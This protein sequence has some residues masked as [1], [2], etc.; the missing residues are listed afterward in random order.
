M[1][2]IISILAIDEEWG[3]GKNWDIPWQS[4]LKN[5]KE[6]TTHTF[7]PDK[8]NVLIMGKNTWESIPENFRPFAHRVNYIV[9]SSIDTSTLSSDI[10]VFLSL[11]AAIQKALCDTKIE[12]IF[13][14]GWAGIYNQAFAENLNDEIYITK[15]SGTYECDTFVKIDFE[16]YEIYQESDIPVG[17]HMYKLLKYKKI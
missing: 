9:S 12:T 2:K 1:K 6:I 14:I 10:E 15:I 17:K 3:I 4:D 7:D 5:F 16:E 11:N 8:Q 13:L